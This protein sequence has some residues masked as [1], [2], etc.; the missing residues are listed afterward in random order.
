MIR[1]INF[2]EEQHMSVLQ[3]FK[4]PSMRKR[5]I[6]GFLTMAGGQ[7]TG[8]LVILSKIYPISN[9]FH[10]LTL[11]ADYGYSIYST[12]GFSPFMI[13]VM[14][15]I[16]SVINGFGNLA[17]AVITDRVGRV[18]LMGEFCSFK[19]NVNFY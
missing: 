1:Q 19:L 13:G 15:G 16:W 8:L 9:L 4:I 6:I 3:M 10:I 2:E 7:M 5:L 17:G 14:I 12:L 18:R 11:A